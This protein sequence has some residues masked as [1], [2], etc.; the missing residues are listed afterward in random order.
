MLVVG[1]TGGIGSGKSAVSKIFA[2]DFNAPVIDADI[3]A[4]QLAETPQVLEQIQV[5]LGTEYFEQNRLLRNKLR[6]AVFSDEKIR[7]KL[8]GILHPL[9]YSEIQQQ[10][11]EIDK[12]STRNY[13]IVVIPLLLETNRTEFIDRILV[14]DCT[15]ELQIQRVT[16]R[17]QCDNEHVKAIIDSQIDRQK[18]LQSADDII[19]NHGTIESLKHQVTILDRQYNSIIEKN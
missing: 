17:D 16:Q 3:I 15:I 5:Q 11:T 7:S 6:L 9:V 19:E 13:C 18:R 1:L 8:E 14:V 12:N 10:L 2:Q 4:K